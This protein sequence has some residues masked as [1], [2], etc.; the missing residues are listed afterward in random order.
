[1]GH[2][3][4]VEIVAPLLLKRKAEE[5]PQLLHARVRPPARGDAYVS[6]RADA[7]IGHQEGCNFAPA[8]LVRIGRVLCSDYPQ[9]SSRRSQPNLLKQS[10]AYV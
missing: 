8:H 2:A 9:S 6:Y 5:P 3:R 1:M 10:R 7:G 4:L